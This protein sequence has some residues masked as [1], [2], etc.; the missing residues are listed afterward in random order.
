MNRSAVRSRLHSGIP[1]NTKPFR[2]RSYLIKYISSPL[3]LQ[4][5]TQAAPEREYFPPPLFVASKYAENIDFVILPEY[6]IIINYDEI[7]ILLR[8]LSG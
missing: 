1:I 2:I 6:T 4:K 8:F 5:T 3:L 7:C